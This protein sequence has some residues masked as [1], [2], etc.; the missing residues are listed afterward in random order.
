MEFKGIKDISEL[1]EFVKQSEYT[2]DPDD[3][4]INQ[5]IDN[6]K[7]VSMNPQPYIDNDGI[8]YYDYGSEVGYDAGKDYL[9]LEGNG[10]ISTMIEIEP[11]LFATDSPHL[12]KNPEDLKQAINKFFLAEDVKADTEFIV[13]EIMGDEG[14]PELDDSFLEM[15]NSQDMKLVVNDIT[16]S[17]STDSEVFLNINVSWK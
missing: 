8:G 13:K 11:L 17:E 15:Y 12:S 6:S 9:V 7:I 10:I 14:R 3:T 5:F 16:I 1:I 2:E 4:I